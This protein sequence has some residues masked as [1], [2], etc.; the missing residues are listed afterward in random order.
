MDP[1]GVVLSERGRAR[2]STWASGGAVVIAPPHAARRRRSSA[3]D[4]LRAAAA[5]ARLR[6]R[7]TRGGRRRSHH[8]HQ[9]PRAK[10]INPFIGAELMKVVGATKTLSSFSCALRRASDAADGH[11]TH[12][13]TPAPPP[14]AQ[15]RAPPLAP[16]LPTPRAPM[17][18]PLR[19]RRAAGGD[20]G[21]G[22]ARTEAAGQHRA[23]QLESE[24]R[25]APSAWTAAA[26][27]PPAS[28]HVSPPSSSLYRWRGWRR[29]TWRCRTRCR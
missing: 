14:A 28:P 16:R 23:A 11:T 12:P 18:L 4:R 13:H 26:R 20:G 25:R 5:V 29:R 10:L 27:S 21:D 6:P 3:R 2:R 9:P 7:L 17:D 15:V 24:V 1:P 8:P 22:R 19:A